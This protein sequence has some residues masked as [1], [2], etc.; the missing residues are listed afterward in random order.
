MVY[1]FNLEYIYTCTCIFYLLFLR[2]SYCI[3]F[4]H[5][6]LLYSFM[7]LLFSCTSYDK[8]AHGFCEVAEAITHAWFVGTSTASDEV[9]LMK[10]LK[11]PDNEGGR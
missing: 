8:A 5:L 7:F 10:I 2:G 4:Y 1:M 11:V 3:L 6:Q 9:V